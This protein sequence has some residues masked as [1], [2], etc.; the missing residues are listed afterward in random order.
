MIVLRINVLH[1]MSYLVEKVFKVWSEF[2][3]YFVKY[4]LRFKE[5][6]PWHGCTYGH[7]S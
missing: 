4:I 2:V 5:R 6:K 1:A 3:L 7:Q